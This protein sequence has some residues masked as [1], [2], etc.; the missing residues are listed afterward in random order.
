[1]PNLYHS[2]YGG[3]TRSKEKALS[4]CRKGTREDGGGLIESILVYEIP[5]LT[6]EVLLDALNGNHPWPSRL[7]ASIQHGRTINE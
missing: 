3:W 6:L 5:N 7:V 2:Y 4:N 1:M